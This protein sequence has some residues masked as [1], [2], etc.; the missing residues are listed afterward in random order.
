[1]ED[2][3]LSPGDYWD[4]LRR[5]KWSLILPFLIILL[6][7]G[8]VA[9]MLPSIYLSQATILIEEQE[10]P[11]DFVM[12]TV[13]SYAEQRMQQL[14]QRIMS[15]SRLVEIIDRFGLYPDLKDTKTTEEIVEQMREDTRLEPVSAEIIDRRTGKPGTA[16]IAFTLSYEGEDPAK[17]QQVANVLTSLYLSENLQVREKQAQETSEFLESE[18]DKIR[19][20]LA[21][22]ESRI[23]G[24]KQ[25][26][27]NELPEMLPAN[28]RSLDD[29]KRNLEVVNERLNSL[30]E[31]ELYL[32]THLAGIK[33]HIEDLD[34]K[35][36][37]RNR[38]GELKV[39]LVHLTK[40]F[41][42]EYPDVKKT[43]AEI[44]E[45]EAQ[46]AE[47]E[48]K[49]DTNKGP[50]DNPTYISVYTQL[51][52]TQAEI[53]LLQDQIGELNL[54]I[55]EYQRRISATPRVEEEYNA[56]VMERNST[57]LKYND[58]MA[59]HMEA[60]VAQGLEK[61]QKGERFTL[62]EPPRLPEK[63][64]KPNRLAIILIGVVLG[65]GAGVGWAALREFSDDAVR[66]AD[67]LVNAFEF[68]VLAGIPE[69]H[70][71]EDIARLRRKRIMIAAGAA[72]AIIAALLVF[73]FAIM[74]LDI[75]WAKLMRRLAL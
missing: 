43:R 72:C 63:P 47:E 41:S 27:L 22:M 5:R 55:A 9:V 17:V 13:T 48:A 40:R 42:E 66:N 44:A 56:L 73:H 59:K 1:M 53:A 12:T 36:S 60:R 24:F 65:I 10:I 51:T 68:P 50:P 38:L 26:H 2:R 45:L 31:R 62:I 54:S 28:M 8:V 37:T 15:F 74:D 61:E 21:L 70:T 57:Q 69:I 14:N 33:P 23:A 7:A 46:L 39:Q 64:F 71:P 52:S 19:T 16:T 32:D 67:H 49:P 34:E 18:L 29:M 35:V 6:A 4:I 11:Q 58:L 20:E 3:V 75:F 25:E 30:R